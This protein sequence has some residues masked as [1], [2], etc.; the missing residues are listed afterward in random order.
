MHWRA[1]KLRAKNK[2]KSKYRRRN[3]IRRRYLLFVAAPQK[4]LLRCCFDAVRHV[5]GTVT[6]QYCGLLPLAE[7]GK[8]AQKTKRSNWG[9]AQ[10]TNALPDLRGPVQVPTAHFTKRY[11]VYTC[12]L[13][14]CVLPHRLFFR[15]VPALLIR[16]SRR[17]SGK[18]KLSALDTFCF[19]CSARGVV[20]RCPC[21]SEAQYKLP[22]CCDIHRECRASAQKHGPAAGP[23]NS[24]GSCPPRS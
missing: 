3:L 20:A 6:V 9:R 17:Q 22:P 5:R 23:V 14:G 16:V 8:K 4:G 11:A 1:C 19:L 18:R 10:R 24:A 7:C 12:K 21:F 13:R 15:V 2:Q